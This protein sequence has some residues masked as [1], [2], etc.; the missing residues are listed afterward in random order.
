MGAHS[1]LLHTFRSGCC[2]SAPSW[3]KQTL[4][5]ITIRYSAIRICWTLRIQYVAA[6]KQGNHSSRRSLLRAKTWHLKISIENHVILLFY[7]L[8][9]R[10][11][12]IPK[13]DPLW[14]VTYYMGVWVL[15]CVELFG[16][17]ESQ[18]HR[19]PLGWIPPISWA[20]V[21]LGQSLIRQSAG[22]QHSAPSAAEAGA[23][24]VRPM[25]LSVN[26]KSVRVL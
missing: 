24:A 21:L 2:C 5:N 19:V 11:M 20:V 14:H 8:P 7:Y 12:Y 3:K 16:T 18:A 17:C 23:Y 6:I 26:W 13:L 22:R 1:W 4:T 9:C 15:F 25:L 10:K